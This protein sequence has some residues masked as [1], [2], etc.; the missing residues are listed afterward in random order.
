MSDAARD[1]ET[2]DDWSMSGRREDAVMADL[3][4]PHEPADPD[5]QIM[6]SRGRLSAE[7]IAMLLRPDLSDMVEGEAVSEPI[8][9]P[10]R[11][12]PNFEDDIF[13]PVD[14]VEE[15]GNELAA[16][17]TLAIRNDCHLPAAIRYAGSQPGRLADA[18][19]D[20]ATGW[21]SLFLAGPSGGVVGALL[22]SPE[23]ASSFI[24]RACGGDGGAGRVSGR[25]LTRLD[26]ALLTGLLSPLIPAIAE[27][28]TLARV[29]TDIRFAEAMATPVRADII[30][31]SVTIG[32][33][34]AAACLAVSDRALQAG[35]QT[36][37][38]IDIAP[39]ARSA[40]AIITARLATLSVPVSRLADLK[41]GSTLMLGIPADQPIELLSGGRD[42]AVIGEG[43][44]GRKGKSIAVRVK[45]KRAALR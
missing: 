12:I 14:P 28:L 25:A 44:I 37:A 3:K 13:A 31:L 24:N 7:E 29:E 8:S 26:A 43:E 21:A 22:L 33:I 39:E 10:A 38:Q 36:A 41:P 5:M 15:V 18:F 34:E 35:S 27:G 42:G 17:L 9:A 4:T 2:D 19:V 1:T 23:L 11:P 16:A 20:R 32:D 6:T 45:Q 30:D 40:T